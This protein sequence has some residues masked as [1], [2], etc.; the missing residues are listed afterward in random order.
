MIKKDPN[1]LTDKIDL[2]QN[3]DKIENNNYFSITRKLKQYVFERIEKQ[4]VVKSEWLYKQTIDINGWYQIH[5]KL[6]YVC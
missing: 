2:T 4:I 6:L 5:A 3:N 1:P